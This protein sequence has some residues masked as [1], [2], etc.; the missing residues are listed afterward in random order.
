MWTKS[1]RMEL[2]NRLLGPFSRRISNQSNGVGR[3]YWLSK[4]PLYHLGAVVCYLC[5]LPDTNN[6]RRGWQSLKNVTKKQKQQ[7]EQRD[8]HGKSRDGFCVFVWIVWYDWM[9]SPAHSIPDQCRIHTIPLPAVLFFFFVFFCCGIEDTH[10]WL[11]PTQNYHAPPLMETDL[12]TTIPGSKY[13]LIGSRA[14]VHT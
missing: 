13:C 14:S 4:L 12:N 2:E 7:L 11:R 10:Q 8:E 5:S 9:S 6:K 1:K 3:T